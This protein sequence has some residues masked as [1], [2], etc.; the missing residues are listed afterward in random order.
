M[1]DER[2]QGHVQGF[3]H[4]TCPAGE[5]ASILGFELILRDAVGY[6]HP[7]V[8]QVHMQPMGWLKPPKN[9]GFCR[10]VCTLLFTSFQG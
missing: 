5:Q 6:L 4:F 3:C 9:A 1:D 10:L 2:T 7:S 8:V